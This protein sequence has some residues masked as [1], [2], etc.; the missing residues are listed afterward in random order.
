MAMHTVTSETVV[1][2]VNTK[3][4]LLLNSGRLTA[5]VMGRILKK[6]GLSVSASLEDM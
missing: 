2:R 1:R 6:L 3:E 4:T 5:T